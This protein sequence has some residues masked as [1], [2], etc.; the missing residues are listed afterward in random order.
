M[1]VLRIFIT[2]LNKN[3]FAKSTRTSKSSEMVNHPAEF[4]LSEDGYRGRSIRDFLYLNKP[5]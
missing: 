5:G 3:K 1:M 2:L 4:R